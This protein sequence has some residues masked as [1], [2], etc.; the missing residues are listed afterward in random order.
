[1]A[2]HEHVFPSTWAKMTIECKLY[3]VMTP[4]IF[5]ASDGYVYAIQIS[6]GVF[7]LSKK[8]HST[9]SHPCG[10]LGVTTISSWYSSLMAGILWGP[11]VS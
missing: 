4:A 7:H 2:A 1:M 8:T 3:K 11:G 6:K 9:K 5:R 10:V